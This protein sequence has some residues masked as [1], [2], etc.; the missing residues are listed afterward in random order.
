MMKGLVRVCACLQK[1]WP[2]KKGPYSQGKAA[3]RGKGDSV[4]SQQQAAAES[5][6]KWVTFSSLK[7]RHLTFAT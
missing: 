3:G 4:A 2:R 7:S 6:G 5:V 1:I